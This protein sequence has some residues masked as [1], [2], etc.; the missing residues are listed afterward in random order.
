LPRRPRDAADCPNRCLSLPR[1]TRCR[2]ACIVG[3]LDPSCGRARLPAGH[4]SGAGVSRRLC[5]AFSARRHPTIAGPEPPHRRSS[6]RSLAGR[7]VRRAG[8]TTP[9]QPHANTSQAQRPA[10]NGCPSLWR[11]AL[12]LGPYRQR[13]GTTIRQPA[14]SFRPGLSGLRFAT[15]PSAIFRSGPPPPMAAETPSRSS[16]HA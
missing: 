4:D 15:A 11:Q 5:P 6:A 16:L 13:Q 9:H 3:A 12:P 1:Q 2:A 14:N 7:V 10:L 8:P